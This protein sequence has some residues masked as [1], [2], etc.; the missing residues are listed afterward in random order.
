MSDETQYI[1]PDDPD[2]PRY[3]GTPV[4]DRE[5]EDVRTQRDAARRRNS[6]VL[7]V[8]AAVLCVLGGVVALKALTGGSAGEAGAEA[9]ADAGAGAAADGGAAPPADLVTFVSPTG[10]IGCAL[11]S[12]GARCD[13]AE[14]SWKPPAK[15]ADCQADWGVGVQVGA[16]AA[17][18]ACASDSV[19]GSGQPLAYGASQ[20]R[21][22]YRCVSSEEGMRCENTTTGHGF[23]IARASYTTF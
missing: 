6:I 12:A 22:S 16:Q 2:V 1:Y 20:E 18:V 5:P 13:I 7:V 17:T 9:G 10:N 3:A 8:V 4:Y 19:L 21:G 14:K 15:P 23:T 11:S